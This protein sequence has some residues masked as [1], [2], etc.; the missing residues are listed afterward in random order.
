M[1]EAPPACAPS[2]D[3]GT[4]PSP[5]FVKN[6]YSMTLLAPKA[7]RK[8]PMSPVALNVPVTASGMPVVVSSGERT[9]DGTRGSPLA[10]RLSRHR[11]AHGPLRGEQGITVAGQSPS[12]S[13]TK[14]RYRVHHQRGALR[15]SRRIDPLPSTISF[16]VQSRLT[17]TRHEVVDHAAELDV[18]SLSLGPTAIAVVNIEIRLDGGHGGEVAALVRVVRGAGKRVLASRGAFVGGGAL[19]STGRI[20]GGGRVHACGHGDRTVS[21][22]HAARILLQPPAEGEV[23][24]IRAGNHGVRV[25]GDENPITRRGRDIN[26][27]VCKAGRGNTSAFAGEGT[28]H[29][30]TLP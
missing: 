26:H 1:Q 2:G 25:V 14:I 22:S 27:S 18:I 24:R 30:L 12:S 15:H 20:G 28:R 29:A 16:T 4:E 3:C 8:L 11:A 23:S 13:T 5:W 17:L 21:G 19:E 9:D 7:P 10:R 6:G